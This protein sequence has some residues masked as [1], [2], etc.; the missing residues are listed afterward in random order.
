MNFSN[1]ITQAIPIT[2]I[3]RKSED[4][5]KLFTNNINC[6]QS[7]NIYDFQR[8]QV[9]FNNGRKE[10][11]TLNENNKDFF[12]PNGL[13][14]TTGIINNLT[15]IDIDDL[16]NP[17]M[18]ELN[19][20]CFATGT[21]FTKT[22]KG[23]H[24]LF[25]YTNKLESRTGNNYGFDIL[26]NNCTA[27][28]PPA[29]YIYKN[30]NEQEL[31]RYKFTKLT[32]EDIPE[33]LI[34]FINNIQPNIEEELT[35]E[36]IPKEAEEDTKIISEEELFK[37]LDAIALKFNEQT[38]TWIKIIWAIYN[39]CNY[40]RLDTLTI[41]HKFSSR[42]S[43]YDDFKV[44]NF[45]VKNCRN[46][47]FNDTQLGIGTLIYYK[48]LSKDEY[49]LPVDANFSNLSFKKLLKYKD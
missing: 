44:D 7:L 21:S 41:I 34:E 11:Y 32:I 31:I 48:N 24:Y 26:N 35:K 8:C 18:I 15:V 17:R 16:K 19:D 22:R 13:L 25:N 47:A 37:I 10:V 27:I 9:K 20:L 30:G 14:V 40:N 5:E 45:L 23:Y 4:L 12:R 49:V 36:Y 33:H 6:L 38:D 42:A 39:V 46:R 3:R 1:S 2:T 29:S 28:F 43:N